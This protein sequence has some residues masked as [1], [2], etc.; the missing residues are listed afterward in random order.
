M[1]FYFSLIDELCVDLIGGYMKIGS[2]F[3]R[4]LL[5]G[6]NSWLKLKEDNHFYLV[7]DGDD[8]LV[9]KKHNDSF[10]DVLII[11]ASS[12]KELEVY[13]E[14]LKQG[15]MYAVKPNWAG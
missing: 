8:Y 10:G 9:Y 14:V 13:L 2:K 4:Q 15:V 12:K 11:K 7:K 3:S 6:V 1:R 5:D